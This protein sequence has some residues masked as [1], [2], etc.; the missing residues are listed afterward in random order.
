VIR[1][2][3]LCAK[4]VF[5]AVLLSVGD[6]QRSRDRVVAACSRSPAATAVG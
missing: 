4:R 6:R 3:L 1:G 2:L 5:I